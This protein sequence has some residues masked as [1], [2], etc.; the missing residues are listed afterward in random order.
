[1]NSSFLLAQAA[2]SDSAVESPI[3]SHRQAP[4]KR[5]KIPVIPVIAAATSALALFSIWRLQPVQVTATP[6]RTPPAPDYETAGMADVVAGV[7][8]VEANT[9][10]IA[11]SVPVSGWVVAVN[12]QAGDFVHAGDVLF[13]LDDRDLRAQEKVRSTQVVAAR[14]RVETARSELAD[15]IVLQTSAERLGSASVI[16]QEERTRKRIAA[17]TAKSQLA[18]AEAAVSLA[19]A[20]LQETRVQLERLVVT[21]PIT[22]TI[23]QSNVRVGQFA[24]TGVLDRPLMLLGN[25]DPLHVRVDIDEQDAWRVQAGQPATGYVRGNSQ[26]KVELRFVRFEPY[27]IPK[28]SLTGDTT[29]RVDTRVLQ[30]IYEIVPSSVRVFTGQQLDVFVGEKRDGLAASPSSTGAQ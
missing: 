6:L 5:R 10:N 18:E 28:Q 3:Y 25:V 21:S 22:G 16:S 11:L 2:H 1:M 12:V 20:E 14:A 15:A 8:L 30:A 19:E 7:G 27:V 13:R 24:P 9:E 17:E 26:K 23:L 29:E 4:R